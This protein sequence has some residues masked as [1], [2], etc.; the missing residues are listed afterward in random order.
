MAPVE[1]MGIRLDATEPASSVLEVAEP[2]SS[3]VEGT[4]EAAAEA[5]AV[6]TNMS[7]TA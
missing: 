4:G 2:A 6:W 3:V 7:E 5:P 1:R